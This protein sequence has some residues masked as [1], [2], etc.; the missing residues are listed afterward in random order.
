MGVELEVVD[1]LLRKLGSLEDQGK[2]AENA[3]L[4]KAGDVIKDAITEEAPVRTGALK[5]SIA[6]SNVKTKEGIKL[7]EVGPDAKSKRGY[8][9]RFLE[10]GTVKMKANPFM[11]RG[12]ER[13]KREALAK[14]Q[15]ELKKGLGL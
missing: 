11:S 3:A 12:Y 14:I 8:I 15:E 9:A 7:V 4:R 5:R 6:R 10:H 2:R 1:E 13:S